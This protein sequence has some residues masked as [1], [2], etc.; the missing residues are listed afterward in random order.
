MKAFLC[1][2]VLLSACAPI[3]PKAPVV[4]VEIPISGPQCFAL[5]GPVVVTYYGEEKATEPLVWTVA[6]QL[7]D[8]GTL[9]ALWEE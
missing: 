3:A 8:F 2:I 9:K 6:S 7:L 5:P 1:A 4:K